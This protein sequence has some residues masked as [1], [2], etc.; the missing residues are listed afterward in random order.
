M[1]KQ[2]LY[3][4]FVDLRKA[5]DSIPPDALW[6]VLSA[7]G[8]EPKVIE[9][10]A[11]LHT[12]TQAAVKQTNENGDWSDIGR[13]V[14]QGCVIAPLLFNVF[15]DCVVRLSL[16]EMPEGCHVRLA[17]RAEGE[18]G[19][20]RPNA[21]LTI[22]ALMYADDLELMSCDRDELQLMLQVFDP[23]CSRM[24]MCVNAAK[25]ELMAVC[26]HGESPESVQ[27]SGGEARYVPSFKYLG[28]V[29]D[30]SASW[31]A[32]V[33]ACISKARGCRQHAYA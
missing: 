23:V 13:G 26:H 22:A 32:E 2:S 27:L 14:R 20:G 30:T 19:G 16:D 17:F 31:A 29:V 11:D 7:Y 9:L 12:G 4:A 3:L 21:V 18:A 25:T 28:G 24:G 5:Y 1:Y 8:V 15:F 6:R 10:L 33:T